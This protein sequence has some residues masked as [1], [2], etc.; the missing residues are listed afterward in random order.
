MRTSYCLLAGAFLTSST[1]LSAQDRQ[2]APLG[3][4]ET[5]IMVTLAPPGASPPVPATN[6]GTWVTTED[7]PSWAVRYE[8]NGMVRF[9]VDVDA[10]GRVTAC[11][12]V[13]SSSVPELD[14]LTCAKISERAS[15]RPARDAKG[16][17]VAGKWANAVRWQIP[18]SERAFLPPPSALVVAMTVEPDGTV[19]NCKVEL[20]E[21]A[22][23]LRG[24]LSC[25][26]NRR[27]EPIR[28]AEGNPQRTRVRTTMRFEHEP[29]SDA[30]SN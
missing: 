23:E 26:E 22:A 30:K 20:A 25:D 2:K 6:P 11:E 24:P 1:H 3:T 13:D 14:E 28:D 17:A 7:Y 5:P 27:Y 15:F 12:I 21:G 29:V 10:E 9:S 18:S 19:S 4:R 8:V 16:K